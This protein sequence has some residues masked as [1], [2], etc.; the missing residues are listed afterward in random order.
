MKCSHNHVD[1]HVASIKYSPGP[2]FYQVAYLQFMDITTETL[3]M[4]SS[5]GLWTFK[6]SYAEFKLF[7]TVVTPLQCSSHR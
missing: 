1:P 3:Y 6:P 7:Y 5:T 4:A 2:L